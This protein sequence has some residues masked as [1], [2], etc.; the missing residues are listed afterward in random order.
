MPKKVVGTTSD[1]KSANS[2]PNGAGGFIVTC[3]Y[4]VV[5][6]IIPDTGEVISEYYSPLYWLGESAFAAGQVCVGAGTYPGAVLNEF[7][8]D[9]MWSS[10]DI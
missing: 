4:G 5:R 2:V 9:F 10:V 3:Y 7:P 6:S 1:R 8:V